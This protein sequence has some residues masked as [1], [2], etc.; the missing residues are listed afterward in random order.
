M[1]LHY[2]CAVLVFF[3]NSNTSSWSVYS[4]DNHIVTFILNDSLYVEKYTVFSGG[5]AT[6]CDSYSYYITDSINFRKYIGSKHN[7]G[8]RIFWN[9]KNHNE[10]EF[11]LE[12]TVLDEINDKLFDDTT[13]IGSYYIPDLIKEGKFE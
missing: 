5:G 1:F 4:K 9:I 12:Y 6:V 7:S 10:I 2:L 11:Y 3:H 8:D 13:K